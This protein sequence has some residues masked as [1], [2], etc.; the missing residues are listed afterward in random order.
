MSVRVKKLIGLFVLLALVFFYAVFATAFASAYLADA[1][2]LVHLLYF[3]TTG[4]LWIVPAALLIRWME[5]E[6]GA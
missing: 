4:L 6:P 5:R 1:G 3:V 2:G